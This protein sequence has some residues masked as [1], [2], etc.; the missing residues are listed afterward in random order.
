MQPNSN[1]FSS[2]SESKEFLKFLINE[3]IYVIDQKEVSVQK[4]PVEENALEEEQS[5]TVE[6]KEPEEKMVL[7]VKP[8]NEILVIFDNPTAKNLPKEDLEYLG[9]ILGAIGKSTEK[10]DFQNV[11]ATTPKAVGY[12]FVIAFTPN[13]QLPV[14]ASTQQYVSTKLGDGQL[15]VADALNNISASTDLRK[16]LWGVLQQV[17]K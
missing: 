16:K 8:K 9:K 6:V 4:E 11:A 5:V 14:A 12:D 3:D 2:M 15:I 10:V 1:Q 17:F 13:H 7:P